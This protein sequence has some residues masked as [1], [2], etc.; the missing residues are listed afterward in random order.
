MTELFSAF[1]N[2]SAFSQAWRTGMWFVSCFDASNV[3]WFDLTI[4]LLCSLHRFVDL[5]N[6]I[7]IRTLVV[8]VLKIRD[9]ERNQTTAQPKTKNNHR[10]T[11]QPRYHPNFRSSTCHNVL[12]AVL[13]NNTCRMS[14]KY[15]HRLGCHH[16]NARCACHRNTRRW[17]RGKIGTR[18]KSIL[19]VVVVLRRLKTYCWVTAIWWGWWRWILHEIWHALLYVG[20]KQIRSRLKTAQ[21]CI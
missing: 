3:Y 15:S 7:A 11:Y 20:C 5:Y 6:I 21:I 10:T 17:W 19:S 2:N 8:G 18:L 12:V 13:A 14:R 9:A 1:S 4:L 16:N